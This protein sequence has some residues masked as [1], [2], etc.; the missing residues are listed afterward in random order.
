MDKLEL[1]EKVCK[2]LAD[3]LSVSQ[4]QVTPQSRLQ[5]DLDADSLDL[6]DAIMALEDEFGVSI[7]EEEVED[8]KTVGQAIDLV[9]QKLGVPA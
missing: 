7:P 3:N 1:Q 4:D 5:E 9:A 8:V 2:I 6:Y